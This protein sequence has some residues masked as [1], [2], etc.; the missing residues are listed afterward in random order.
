ML[1]RAEVDHHLHPR[2]ILVAFAVEPARRAFLHLVVAVLDA[3][4]NPVPPFFLGLRRRL[5]RGLAM[6][7]HRADHFGNMPAML[8]EGVDDAG[9]EAALR[10]AVEEGVGKTARHQAEQGVRVGAFGPVLAQ[11]LAAL[12]VDFEAHPA[13]VH[14]AGLEA[15]GEDDDVDRV[16]LPLHDDP[17]GGDRLE[18]AR[19][20]RAT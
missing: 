8:L 18:P 19:P 13:L 9:G 20:Y 1:Q 10:A 17:G 11:A 7:L 6:F 12:A 5:D 15:G 2:R 14:R 16:F 3:G 4:E